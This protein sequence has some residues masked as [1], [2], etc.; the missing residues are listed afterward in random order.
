V[1]KKGNGGGGGGNVF[2]KEHDGKKIRKGT[3]ESREKIRMRT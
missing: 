3:S 1:K 2:N